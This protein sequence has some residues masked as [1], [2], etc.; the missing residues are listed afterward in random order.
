[1]LWKRNRRGELMLVA[2]F[3][4]WFV[5]SA[6]CAV[7]GTVLIYYLVKLK[8]QQSRRFFVVVTCTYYLLAIVTLWMGFAAANRDGVDRTRCGWCGKEIE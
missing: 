4:V 3:A 5:I 7:A 2:W 1:M 8:N 6:V